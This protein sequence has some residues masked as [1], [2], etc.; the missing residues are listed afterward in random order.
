MGPP[1][2]R[3]D[4]GGRRGPTKR[5][6]DSRRS[7][8]GLGKGGALSGSA[9]RGRATVCGGQ[10]A[11]SDAGRLRGSSGCRAGRGCGEARRQLLSGCLTPP[12]TRTERGESTGQAQCGSSVRLR[13]AGLCRACVLRVRCGKLRLL[14][15]LPIL[16]PVELVPSHHG[17]LRASRASGG[18]WMGGRWRA[19]CQRVGG[20]QEE[21]N[22]GGG[23]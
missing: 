9:L 15:P 18:G 12:F 2:W 20:L 8:A 6:R 4:G 21:R 3:C 14:L 23:R 19:A 16:Q 22:V 10:G 5:R 1:A 17:N 11:G 7:A 13:S